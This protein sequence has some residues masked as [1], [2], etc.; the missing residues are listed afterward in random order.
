MV[1]TGHPARLVGSAALVVAAVGIG[2][3]VVHRQ[4]PVSQAPTTVTAASAAT[5]VAPSGQ[6][7][8]ARPGDVVP[9]GYVVRTG[10]RGRAA[11]RT[12]RRVVYVEANA[13]VAV[14]DGARE[15]LR[16]GGAVVDAQSGPGLT[17]MVADDRLDVP[18]GSA[19]EALRSVT[20][21][22]GAL[23]G[24]AVL[25]SSAG[26]RLRLPALSQA[27][28]GGDALPAGTT[29]LQLTDN[30]AESLAVP[31]LVFDDNAIRTLADGIN[32]SGGA[33]AAAVEAAWSGPQASLPAGT[34]PSDRVLP[35][36][37]AEATPAGGGTVEQR[38][39]RV[40]RWRQSAGSWGV[41]VELLHGDAQSVER[42]FTSASSGEST[43]DA[44][45]GAI[46]AAA[47]SGASGSGASGSGAS[48]ASGG[49]KPGGRPPSSSRPASKR[50]PDPTGSS[51]PGGGSAGGG[52][53]GGGSGGGSGGGASPTP[54]PTPTGLIGT[55]VTTVPTVVG[56]VLGVL[57]TPTPKPKPKHH[58]SAGSGGL[59]NVV[60]G[61]LG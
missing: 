37:I 24:D 23:A 52:A 11:L 22:V 26:R 2:A 31:R 6:A 45:A 13:A 40:I 8:L 14:L 57:P 50:T 19:A 1:R 32:A 34:A 41:V 10:P 61:V 47:G 29:T 30:W 16:T 39:G 56:G 59:L 15:Q 49:R 25:S 58:A 55:V 60:G 48:A 35:M 42:A 28:F 43:G 27:E 38:Y 9:A 46:T 17:L 18:P 53:G 33:T 44:G 54:T 20:V 4:G 21:Q 5:I 12:R 36:V 51:A 3:V 7:R